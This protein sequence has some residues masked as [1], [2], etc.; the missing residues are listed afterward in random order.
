M[1]YSAPS[2]GRRYNF[3]QRFTIGLALLVL[4]A[5]VFNAQVS[6]MREET[7]DLAPGG[8]VRITNGRGSV[9]IECWED[10]VVRVLAEKKGTPSAALNPADLLLM[11]MSNS[12]VIES[13]GVSEPS[14]IDLTVYVPYSSQVQISAGSFPV[15]ITGSPANVTV[16]TTAGHISYRVPRND[17]SQFSLHTEKGIVRSNVQLADA[18]KQ[19][20]KSLEGRSGD[21]TGSVILSSRTGNITLSPAPNV[22][23]IARASTYRPR[24]TF[25]PPVPTNQPAEQARPGSGTDSEDQST[26]GDPNSIAVTPDQ[27]STRPPV[28]QQEPAQ[29]PSGNGSI[30]LGGV[31]QSDDDSSTYSAGPFS[32][33]RTERTTTGGNTG[34]SVRIIPSNPAGIR[35]TTPDAPYQ[36]NRS[37]S[38][39][40]QG[41]S[42]RQPSQNRT[43]PPPAGNGS[44]NLGGSDVSD[45]EESS[46]RSGPFSRP[47]NERKT[48][49]GNT[50]LSVRIIPST[51]GA[52]RPSNSDPNSD[53]GNVS[54]DDRDYSRSPQDTSR[55]AARTADEEETQEQGPIARATT[56]PPV[57]RRN[58]DSSNE[59][60]AP[61]SSSSSSASAD[62]EEVVT[63]NASLVNMN[64]SVTNRSGLAIGNLKKDSFHIF[65]N[66]D[67]QAIEMFS[68]NS[69]PF[70]L[71]LLI[72]LSGSITDKLDVIKAAAVNFLK[73]IGP[74]DKV[75]I[76]VFT[77]QI[78]LVSRLT[79]DKDFLRDRIKSIEKPE[80]ATAFYEA[81]WYAL[82]DTLEGT[83]GQRNAIV[84]LSDGVDSSLDR[85]YPLQPRISFN[86]LAQAVEESDVTLFPI[87]LDTEY[88][89]VFER[90]TTTVE[91][92]EM[93]RT[94]L[95]KLAEISGGQYFQ[96]EKS[97]DLNDVYKQVAEALRTVYT[98]G[99]YSTNPD[100][101]GRFRRVKVTVD[102]D[103][104]AVRTRRGYYAK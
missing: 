69:A 51:P 86:R 45:D 32:R 93:A 15:D 61:E 71:V 87:Y 14:R 5:P 54:R 26:D 83:R 22:A 20:L 2:P 104:A 12:V 55:S 66:G 35:P 41:G 75:A 101:D 30:N 50:G 76:V 40:D 102:R 103:D 23:R 24:P 17:N 28:R 49:G 10:P 21:G 48:T 99:Y 73:V 84:L 72:D 33:P 31:D 96:A 37:D 25:Q 60:P 58:T 38:D 74:R 11:S 9:R 77:D 81:V 79:S 68:P 7:F 4:V 98:I 67:P 92:Y 16:E 19:G 88:E 85:R 6:S 18:Q 70:N 64:V 36:S 52:G 3:F 59:P 8:L 44:I 43:A 91:S 46:Y 1:F 13:R 97:K 94:Q 80:G 65:E 56:R 47:R 34:L 53:S 29:Q 63:L 39:D 27:R 89:E 82:N 90:G 62:S 95:H 100:K 57:L 42:G 78:R